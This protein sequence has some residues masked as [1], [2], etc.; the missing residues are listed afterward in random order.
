MPDL[1]DPVAPPAPAAPRQRMPDLLDPIAAAIPRTPAPPVSTPPTSIAPVSAPIAAPPPRTVAVVSQQPIATQQPDLLSPV[2]TPHNDQIFQTAERNLRG[3]NPSPTLADVTQKRLDE[4]AAIPPAPDPN[5]FEPVPS[6]PGAV[7][8]K[9]DLRPSPTYLPMNKEDFEAERNAEPGTEIAEALKYSTPS[10][11]TDY[12]PAKP[13]IDTKDG[14]YAVRKDVYDLM[15]AKRAARPAP[16]QSLS[17]D[18]KNVPANVGAGVTRAAGGVVGTVGGLIQSAGEP[19]N[20]EAYAPSNLDPQ[21][22]LKEPTALMR[23]GQAVSRQGD[24]LAAGAAKTEEDLP[25]QGTAGKLLVGA[26]TLGVDAAMGTLTGG[27]GFVAS[28][29]GRS[30]GTMYVNARSQGDDE[31]TA[32]GK[33]LIA[34]FTAA[35]TPQLAH[36]LPPQIGQEI[37]TQAARAYLGTGGM[38]AAQ[39]TADELTLKAG[40]TLKVD[41][42]HVFPEAAVQGLIGVAFHGGHSAL[43]AHQQRAANPGPE[44]LAPE[45]RAEA[46]LTR[47]EDQATPAMQAGDYGAAFG[48]PPAPEGFVPVEKAGKQPPIPPTVEGARLTQVN[49][50]PSKPPEANSKT[51][52][53]DSSTPQPAAPDLLSPVPPEVQ[54]EFDARQKPPA[55]QAGEAKPETATDT[56]G[57]GNVEQRAAGEP[58]I[59][60]ET[61]PKREQPPAVAPE[62]TAEP[63]T[64]E[65]PPAQ[66]QP[67]AA[68]EA[69]TDLSS[70]GHPSVIEENAPKS[71]AGSGVT[72]E[73]PKTGKLDALESWARGHLEKM[74]ST[75][76]RGG[77]P[78]DPIGDTKR[79]ALHSLILAS[80]AAK[81]GIKFVE[82]AADAVKEIPE[83]AKASKA[84]LM[85]V[86]SQARR[87]GKM[88]EDSRAS[89]VQS[90]FTVGG[91][92]GTKT[93][94][95]RAVGMIK[96]PARIATELD[97]LRVKLRAEAKG[98]REGFKEAQQTGK[99]AREE[100]VRLIKDNLPADQAGKLLADVAKA[101]TIGKVAL[102][103]QKA[104]RILADHQ[105]KEALGNLE[106]LTGN[107]EVHVVR[108]SAPV[109]GR[110]KT[111]RVMGDVQPDELKTIS[112]KTLPKEIRDE[113]AGL[114]EKGRYL[115]DRLRNAAAG[116]SIEQKQRAVEQ[117]HE[118]DR[119]IRQTVA[120]HMATQELRVGDR[121]VTRDKIASE[122]V[123]KLGTAKMEAPRTSEATS[124]SHESAKR[125]LGRQALNMDAIASNMVG[126]DSDAY[127]LTIDQVRQGQSAYHAEQRKTHDAFAPALEKA[128]IPAGSKKLDDWLS[129]REA[130]KLPDLGDF[131]MTRNEMLDIVATAGDPQTRHLVDIGVPW[132]FENHLRETPFKLSP[133][134]VEAL[135]GK[136]KPEELALVDVF[137]KLNEEITPAAMR[138]KID[139]SGWAPEPHKGYYPR[140]RNRMQGEEAG[141]PEGWRG[142]LD[143]ALENIS[144]MKERAADRKQPLRVKGFV[145]RVF[146]HFDDTAKLIH[147]AEPVRSAAAVWQHPEVAKSVTR[148]Y[149]ESMNQRIGQF[150]SDTMM[151]RANAPPG[152]VGRTW[153]AIARN[154]SRAWLQLNPSPMAK[155]MVGGTLS[156]L[157]EF[158]LKDWSHGVSKMLSPDVY[159]RMIAGS[160]VAWSRYHGGLYGAYSPLTGG[161]PETVAE[162]SFGQA[163]KAW[164]PAE[165]IDAIKLMEYADGVP[166][167]A[168]WAASE[169][170]IER[171]QPDL[172][173]EEMTRAVADKFERALYRT[174]N[175]GS[176]TEVS[177][178]ASSA[179]GNPMLS[180]FLMFKSD[181]AK[182]YSML[183]MMK[184]ADPATRAKT[185]AAIALNAVASAAAMYGLKQGATSIGQAIGGAEKDPKEQQKMR[186]AAMWG[187]VKDVVGIVPL[188]ASIVESIR[189]WN[190]HGHA[191]VASNPVESTIE[192]TVDLVV[193]AG[194]A[195]TKW[196]ES[197][198]GSDAGQKAYY[199][200]LAAMYKASKGGMVAG[201]VPFPP[202]MNYIERAWK[203]AKYTPPD[204]R[205]EEKQ[206]L[207]EK[208]KAVR[209]AMLA[210]TVKLL[211]EKNRLD[212]IPAPKRTPQ[213]RSRWGS[214]VRVE[215]LYDR[216]REYL[217]AGRA[218]AAAET[219]KEIGTETKAK[220]GQ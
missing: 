199:A 30:A 138:A 208:M 47:P 63:Q 15:Q 215:R 69:V 65:T 19:L 198:G 172:K 88:D 1:L 80:K 108:P 142:Y 145:G 12:K 162:L 129:K 51:P 132:S 125:L 203:A 207:D 91:E 27:T 54:A 37:A 79:L 151:V 73:P 60:R 94:V 218:E 204:P 23:G 11:E 115:K 120:N 103:I 152:V 50:A 169:K 4:G 139:L 43:G 164:K 137:R 25:V 128:G 83:L 109:K 33:A 178:F 154:V 49:E 18:L 140:S 180:A 53:G 143:R 133:R 193:N 184:D 131:S 150:L 163:V 153:Q 209:G 214:L 182:K 29:A 149:G 34:G 171:T 99:G 124:V 64:A 6:V 36:I 44:R 104:Q 67:P 110:E 46:P 155:N 59:A 212:K 81:T 38:V 5:E 89:F 188:G 196:A 166:L 126:P 20:A 62:R 167:R 116:A 56:S 106:D 35:V 87:L 2:H 72:G 61:P 39:A 52:E 216:Y 48:V 77:V 176:S 160:G 156:L 127:K 55:P 191:D 74:G 90:A 192:G 102:G 210:G 32:A 28:F 9:M 96:D 146:D 41:L 66:R 92:E 219:L 112:L 213:E 168:A 197:D 141:L 187:A 159:K 45:R 181:S 119:E 97:A 40:T 7:K 13:F 130:V 101:D 189:L 165:A 179:R 121:L 183:A 68:G 70:S 135:R 217:R 95:R 8:R 24:Y 58:E 21:G 84:H 16:A 122:V 147:L 177:G 175:G 31:Q 185:L 205:L 136:L 123:E 174:Q 190:T 3:L 144:S 202:L 93:T 10:G 98:S 85:K 114:I 14:R 220:G 186:D 76:L 157:P 194:R 78:V 75:G 111:A 200:M 161:R 206:K 158:D 170:F 195:L 82:W 26:G 211:D 201:G 42:S 105:V 107:M 22:N 118:I 148:R 113:V 100:L 17:Q 57:V 173:G 134:D 71:S 117:F 86:F